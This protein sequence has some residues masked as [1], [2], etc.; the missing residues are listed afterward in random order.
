MQTKGIENIIKAMKNSSVTRII[1][2]TGTGV[3]FEGDKLSL[4]DRVGNIIIKLIDR[5]RIIDG[6]KHAE[7][8]KNSELSWTILRVL[9]LSQKDEWDNKYK[10][11]ENGPA[12]NMT[13]RKK[14]ARILV[15]LVDSGDYI[16]K[17]P[18]VSG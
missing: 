18:V 16:K 15:D 17:A 8:L 14:V 6:I 2:L 3:R 1:S 9:K 13:S 4:F 12:E 7:V 10:L 5:E 11:T